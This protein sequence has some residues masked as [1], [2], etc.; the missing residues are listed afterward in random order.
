M[1]TYARYDTV[2]DDLSVQTMPQNEFDTNCL[3]WEV[4]DGTNP[5][6]LYVKGSVLKIYPAKPTNEKFWAFDMES[7]AWIDP[8]TA[9]DLA[10]EFADAKLSAIRQINAEAGKVRSRYITISPGMDMQYMDKERQAKEFLV[11]PEPS[12][13]KYPNIYAEVGLYSD[14]DTPTRVATIIVDMAN[15][16]RIVSASLE[17]VRLGHITQIEACQNIDAI[18]PILNSFNSTVAAFSA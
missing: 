6:T 5:N 16:W 8:R 1:T 14:Q 7:D 11:D 17:Q 10:K 4:P 3:F 9:D 2:A 13:A 12:A 15:M 18:A